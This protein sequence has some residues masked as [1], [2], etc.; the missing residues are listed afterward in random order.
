MPGILD[1]V[2]QADLAEFRKS[3]I[4][5]ILMTPA[6]S[7]YPEAMLRKVETLLADLAAQNIRV[8]KVTE[9]DPNKNQAFTGWIAEH[10]AAPSRLLPAIA[11]G[12]GSLI[13]C[14]DGRPIHV[15]PT[16]CQMTTDQLRATI[17]DAL[18]Q[19]MA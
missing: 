19:K 8:F 13:I 11:I 3:G 14:R 2:T 15:E 6:W 18:R 10:N 9:D 7:S 16:T 4:S 1:I 12:A 17:S 5:V